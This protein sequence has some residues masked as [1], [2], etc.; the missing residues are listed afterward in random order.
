MA[1]WKLLLT[2]SLVPC[3]RSKIRKQTDKLL[4]FHAPRSYRS[5]VTSSRAQ[6]ACG[7][8]DSH[9]VYLC[10]HATRGRLSD[11][12]SFNLSSNTLFHLSSCSVSFCLYL[13]QSFSILVKHSLVY[14]HYNLYSLLTKSTHSFFF[15]YS[16][17]VSTENKRFLNSSFIGLLSFRAML[18]S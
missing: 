16:L 18:L 15:S 17:L 11:T 14:I 13:A 10:S 4:S 5:K 7:Y 2:L 6:M 12:D 9:H 8:P 1:C 3:S